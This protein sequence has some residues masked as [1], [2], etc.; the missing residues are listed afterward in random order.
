[1]RSKW[2]FA[3]FEIGESIYD[4][5][6]MSTSLSDDRASQ[7]GGQLMEIRVPAGSN[8]LF[9]NGY[10]DVEG[11][12]EVLFGRDTELSVVGF[13]DDGIPILEVVP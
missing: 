4:S 1:M 6:Y 13:N 12:L 2:S 7:F 8:A 5:G 10:S 11:E 3:D 9:L